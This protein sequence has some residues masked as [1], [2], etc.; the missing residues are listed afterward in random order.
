M[1]HEILC[2][3][4][5]VV[6][7]IPQF[8]TPALP[9]PGGLIEV[10]PTR[11]VPGGSACNTG[12]ALAT[13]GIATKI[14]ARVGDDV[15]GRE[16][17]DCFEAMNRH[18]AN[19]LCVTP[20]A[21]TGH[22]IVLSPPGVDR[23][24]MH[25]P[26][27][28]ATF[29]DS[30]VADED[31]RGCRVVHFGYPPVMPAI[32]RDN[33]ASLVR[34]FARARAVGCLTSLDLCGV[35]R[36]GW[37]G[38]VDWPAF[39][40]NVLPHTDLFCPSRDELT[41]LLGDIDPLSLG[42]RVL[43][44]KQGDAGLHIRTIDAA[45]ALGEGWGNRDLRAGTYIVDVVGTNGAGDTTIAGFLAGLVR[46]HTIERAADL[47]SAAGAHCVQQA[48]ATSGLCTLDELLAFIDSNPPRRQ[49]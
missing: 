43:V 27:A 22:T 19:G 31:L 10:G 23:R 14:I 16:L 46:G 38:E 35:D 4:Q 8:H 13:F 45:S 28:N 18:L 7:L 20:K 3:G 42:C 11:V 9:P 2:C 24:F 26:G 15:F 39:F 6:D 36:S 12:L 25:C 33:G 17:G 30:D 5:A 49:S 32:C 29:T 47:A 41:D 37:A 40:A 34:L 48:D 21:S 44:M 1:M